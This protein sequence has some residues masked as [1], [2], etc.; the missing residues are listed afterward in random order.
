[1]KSDLTDVPRSRFQKKK[2]RW[3]QFWKKYQTHY[4]ANYTIRFL[5]KPA[6]VDS[7]LL[8]EGQKYS[9]D[10]SFQVT[11]EAGANIAAPREFRQDY[12][13]DRHL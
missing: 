11:W 4:R 2:K 10:N 3:W 13:Q 12:S 7:E 6:C 8:F 1:M 9:K 5:L